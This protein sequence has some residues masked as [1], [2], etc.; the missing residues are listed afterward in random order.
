MCRLRPNLAD[1]T[2]LTCE[3]LRST[4]S[5]VLNAEPSIVRATTADT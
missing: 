5:I 3:T 1:V 2:H 4:H